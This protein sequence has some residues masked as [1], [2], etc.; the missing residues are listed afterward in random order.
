VEFQTHEIEFD[1]DGNL[2]EPERL[3][4]A[5]AAIKAGSF[6]DLIVIAH[7]WNNDIADARD[8]YKKYLKHTA[9]VLGSGKVPGLNNRTFAVITV[10]WPS[11]KFTDE[12]LIPGGGAAGVADSKIDANILLQ[13]EA[14]KKEPIRLGE[15][16]IDPVASAIVEQ[17]KALLPKLANDAAARKEF[18]LLLRSLLNPND[19]HRDDASEEFFTADPE[20]I[21]RELSK[22]VMV[23]PAASGG[24]GAAV[25]GGG[26][27][28]FLGDL[29]SGINSGVRRLLNFTT[30]YKM[31]E[32]A[33]AVGRVGV[34][35]MLL[36]IREKLPDIRIHLVG[37]S[38]GGRLVT[39]A[40]HGLDDSTKV[41]T[42]TLLQAAYSHNGLSSKFDG[43]RDGAFRALVVKKR[44]SGPIC[45]T[46]TH[47]D[48]AVGIL[49]PLASRFSK[50][51][52]SAL[53]DANDPYGGMGRNGAR[54][55]PEASDFK[56]TQVGQSLTLSAGKIHN[57]EC[58]ACITDHS[59]IANAP[60]AYLGLSAA[61][62]T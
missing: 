13:L 29:A 34:A 62:K 38:F 36:R 15:A 57:F 47:N 41:Q 39:A 5:I 52:A 55:T 19:A 23:P 35:P 33:G 24:G 30:Y 14:L 50:D 22:P 10:F 3:P 61:A 27:A 48:R 28:N 45:I 58:S 51:Q 54:R 32:R 37:H 16:T 7:G 43:Q 18:V 46:Y 49:Y 59:D 12:E 4:Q 20:T 44:V 21:L 11:K 26:A 6:S 1:K 56:L 42:M 17:A 60:V 40:A 8:L 31:K 2:F 25:L 53:G 9:D